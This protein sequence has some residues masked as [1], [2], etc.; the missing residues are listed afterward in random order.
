MLKR[1]PSDKII[2]TENAHFS[3]TITHQNF[4][5]NL[6]LLYEPRRIKHPPK[7]L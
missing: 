4:T 5:F 3:Q 2:G 7:Y 6:R 1:F